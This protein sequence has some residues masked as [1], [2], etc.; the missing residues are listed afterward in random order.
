[1]HGLPFGRPRLERRRSEECVRPAFSTATRCRYDHQMHVLVHIRRH[2]IHHGAGYPAAGAFAIAYRNHVPRRGCRL[3]VY[4]T[5]IGHV[6]FKAIHQHCFACVHART[7][8][9]RLPNEVAHV[10]RG[11]VAQGEIRRLLRSIAEACRVR[12]SFKLPK[13]AECLGLVSSAVDAVRVAR[14]RDASV[15]ADIKQ[16]VL[17]PAC[18]NCCLELPVHHDS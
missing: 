15:L 13:S 11:F 6:R 3:L 7:I 16:P 5:A 9:V 2:Q 17:R 4:H 10:C 1:M 12:F 14:S 8:L 18:P